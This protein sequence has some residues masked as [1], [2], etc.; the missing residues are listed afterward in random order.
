[1]TQSKKIALVTGASRG[2][3]A[4]IAKKLATDNIQVIGTATSQNGADAISQNLGSN[5]S[6]TGMVY[7]NRQ[8][9]AIAQLVEAITKNY[10]TPTILVNNAGITRDTLMLRMTDDNWNEV[11]EVN[12]NG[13]F[14]LTKAL[15]RGMMKSQ[16]G[17]IITIGSVVGH[18]GNAGQVN[19]SATKA[20]VAGFSRSLAKEV[21]SRNIT[22]NVVAP[23]FIATDMTDALN[24]E[25]KNNLL[26]NIPLGRMGQ[27]DDI[28]HS[29]AFLASE[30]SGYITGETL[31]VNGGMYMQ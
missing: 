14:R 20:A 19:Y 11:I 21:G 31:H 28:A 29:V 23:G 24:E 25:Q 1:M 18:S 12:L 4:A 8:P 5:L 2:I 17:R 6:V 15:L 13:V 26:K 9:N 10:G 3:G 7:D 16:F 22:V 27:V 30:H